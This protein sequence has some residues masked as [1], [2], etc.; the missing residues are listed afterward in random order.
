VLPPQVA[1]FI[2]LCP[3][4]ERAL[5]GAVVV[6]VGTDCPEFRALRA[7]DVVRWMEQPLVLD[8]GGFLEGSLGSDPR[9]RYIKVG[10]AA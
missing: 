2:E 7:E 6:L 9:I 8:P 10:K 4:I 1:A 3:S 5:G